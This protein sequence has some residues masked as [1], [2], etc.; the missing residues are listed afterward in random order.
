MKLQQDSQKKIQK[1]IN[2]LQDDDALGV[3]NVDLKREDLS[4]N[5]IHNIDAIESNNNAMNLDH[6]IAKSVVLD[7]INHHLHDHPAQSSSSSSSSYRQSVPR[8]SKTFI[9]RSSIAILTNDVNDVNSQ[10]NDKVDEKNDNNHDQLV[11]SGI[12]L[13]K[14]IIHKKDN[15]DK[16]GDED[17]ES[18]DDNGCDDDFNDDDDNNDKKSGNNATGQQQNQELIKKVLLQEE[19]KKS[20]SKH[21]A[22][23]ITNKYEDNADIEAKLALVLKHDKHNHHHQQQQQ[24]QDSGN[25]G[26]SNIPYTRDEMKIIRADLAAKKLKSTKLSKQQEMEKRKNAVNQV[27]T[28]AHKIL[29]RSSSAS[30]TT[31]TAATTTTTTSSIVKQQEKGKNVA[32]SQQQKQQRFKNF[33]TKSNQIQQPKNIDIAESSYDGFDNSYDRKKRYDDSGN[34]YDDGIDYDGNNHD[35]GNDIQFELGDIYK[36]DYDHT[37]STLLDQQQQQQQYNLEN[38]HHHHNSQSSNSPNPQST[39]ASAI[40]TTTT[41]TTPFNSSHKSNLKSNVA[42]TSTTTSTNNNYNNND[43]MKKHKVSPRKNDDHPFLTDQYQHNNDDDHDQN[44]EV[45]RTQISSKSQV[46]SNKTSPASTKSSATNNQK[47]SINISSKRPLNQQQTSK[48]SS[49]IPEHIQNS[50]LRTSTIKQ[51]QQLKRNINGSKSTELLGYLS[52]NNRSNYINYNSSSSSSGGGGDK[53]RS[54]SA[55]RIRT[56]SNNNNNNNNNNRSN[57]F[58]NNTNRSTSRRNEKLNERE[59]MLLQPN[60]NYHHFKDI[61]ELI[62]KQIPPPDKLLDRNNKYGGL[63]HDDDDDK[64]DRD[65]DDNDG[66]HNDST[67]KCR[68][69]D[70]KSTNFLSSSPSTYI[71]YFDKTNKYNTMMNNRIN[72]NNSSSSNYNNNDSIEEQSLHES[73]LLNEV[74]SIALQNFIQMNKV[75]KDVDHWCEVAKEKTNELQSKL[76]ASRESTESLPHSSMN[77]E[78]S[79]PNNYTNN[80]NNFLN[81]KS[82]SYNSKD[83]FIPI[84]DSNKISS[85]DA[86]FRVR[87]SLADRLVD[88]LDNILKPVTNKS[89]IIKTSNIYDRNSNVDDD[90]IA[91]PKELFKSNHHASY[92]FNNYNKDKDIMDEIKGSEFEDSVL[93]EDN[94]DIAAEDDDDRYNGYDDDNDNDEKGQDSPVFITQTNVFT[95]K[96]IDEIILHDLSSSSPS[97]RPI[98]WA[99]RPYQ[100]HVEDFAANDPFFAQQLGR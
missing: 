31:T 17:D 21:G 82:S 11:S 94:D 8:L 45:G 39:H 74:S 66:N 5:L 88:N 61:F 25:G 57:G 43:E 40:N 4:S 29:Q 50:L 72:N 84:I 20:I 75:L 54:R 16:K 99:A 68:I 73:M 13:V 62:D 34:D 44:D 26:R 9:N 76:N 18:D 28:N 91:H 86:I 81:V 92:T 24:Q 90:V 87:A 70:S 42:T 10:M 65:D 46:S 2:L 37:S 79:A 95:N 55:D 63:N 60:D 33:T 93:M 59:L 36:T 6:S 49:I 30:A 27:L 67:Y 14:R 64:N 48:N 89:S 80:N 22:I 32:T 38:H 23:I 58:N 15:D 12:Q 69:K 77:I 52:T 41:T 96:S 7:N 47:A 51:T 19:E 100:P 97:K 53:Y 1:Q 85:N 78:S 56:F 71:P 98:I 3:L 35:D 83:S